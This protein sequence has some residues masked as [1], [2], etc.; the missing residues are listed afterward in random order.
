MK[1]I[2]LALLPLMVTKSWP[3]PVNVRLLLMAIKLF[4]RVIVCGVLK[5]GEKTTVSP[6]AA[7]ATASRKLQSASQ[8]A[9]LVSSAFVTISVEARAYPA[10]NKQRKRTNKTGKGDFIPK[11]AD[12]RTE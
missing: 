9:S 10:A 3:V 11:I 8:T 2:R 6:G 12:A 7:A 1:K 4:V 5:S